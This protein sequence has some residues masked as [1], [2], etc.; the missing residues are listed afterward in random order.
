MSTVFGG[1]YCSERIEKSKSCREYLLIL[2]CLFTC[3]VIFFQRKAVSITGQQFKISHLVLFPN[4]LIS[5]FLFI[6]FFLLLFFF[7]DVILF[8]SIS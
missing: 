8:S 3:F 4:L 2:L 7:G 5:A 1:E 6:H